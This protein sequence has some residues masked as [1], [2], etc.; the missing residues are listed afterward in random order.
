MSCIPRFGSGQ[1]GG[2]PRRREFW[3]DGLGLGGNTTDF[4]CCVPRELD[5]SHEV[6]SILVEHCMDNSYSGQ[7][8]KRFR[9]LKI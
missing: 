9:G 1:I 5:A 8:K 6:S 7:G 3:F 4:G 2:D